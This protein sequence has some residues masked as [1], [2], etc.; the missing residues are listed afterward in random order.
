MEN[1]TKPAIA[2]IGKR[3]MI[4]MTS[5]NPCIIVGKTYYAYQLYS[6]VAVYRLFLDD[7]VSVRWTAQQIRYWFEPLVEEVEYT[8]VQSKL[9]K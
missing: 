3:P 8:V 2:L 6:D 1:N 7:K 9:T 5:G 4:N